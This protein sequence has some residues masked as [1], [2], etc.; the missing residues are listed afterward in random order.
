MTLDAPAEQTIGE[1]VKNYRFLFPAF[2]YLANC[3]YSDLLNRFNVENLSFTDDT[4][5]N[6]S[7]GTLISAMAIP[8]LKR[9]GSRIDELQVRY[10][11]FMVLIE[12]EKLK[13]KTGS[14]PEKIPLNII[15][16]FN[17]VPLH[18]K[19]GPH[20][21]RKSFLTK[22]KKNGNDHVADAFELE[23]CTKTIQGIG[24]W[25]CGMNQ[26]DD[27]GIFG[28]NREDGDDLRA[29]LTISE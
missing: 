2:W 17:G 22:R 20:T 6:Y 23:Y 9:A 21:V 12:A 26:H 10:Q 28:D 24:V 15:D 11:T 5:R 8:P 16:H 29:L 3:N 13:R 19:V 27:N 1:G 4:I 18:Y 14:Y 7:T 25:S